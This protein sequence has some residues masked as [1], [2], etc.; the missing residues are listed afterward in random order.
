M[1]VR[2]TVVDEPSLSESLEL[3]WKSTLACCAV[4][5]LGSNNE[6]FEMLFT[7]CRAACGPPFTPIDKF[8]PD[9]K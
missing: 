6:I 4:L 5:T 3:D 8:N 1:W 2:Q 9:V 7:Q